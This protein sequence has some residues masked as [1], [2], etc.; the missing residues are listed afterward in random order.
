MGGSA[1]S[2]LRS[3]KCSKQWQKGAWCD[4]EMSSCHGWYDLSP[5]LISKGKGQNSDGSWIEVMRLLYLDFV[6]RFRQVW[7]LNWTLGL[8]LA[9]I[10]TSDWTWVPSVQVQVWTWAWDQTTTAQHYAGGINFSPLDLWSLDSRMTWAQDRATLVHL[11]L[12]VRGLLILDHCLAWDNT[13]GSSTDYPKIGCAFIPNNAHDLCHRTT[14]CHPILQHSWPPI[15]YMRRIIPNQIQVSSTPVLRP[16]HTP[17]FDDCVL[18]AFPSCRS[19][20]PHPRHVLSSTTMRLHSG[21]SRKD[22]GGIG[23]VGYGEPHLC[24]NCF[25]QAK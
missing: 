24:N 3:L 2:K 11:L 14:L 15:A 21:G 23:A 6:L 10:Q 25:I 8:V 4:V 9:A 1:K 22:A 19:F 5:N 17:I 12:C 18:A 13:S 16:C 7:T 20:I